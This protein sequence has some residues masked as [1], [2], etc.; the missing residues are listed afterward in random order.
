V[1]SIWVALAAASIWSPDLISGT[2]DTH[3]PIAAFTDWFYA[4][5]A[6]GLVLMAFSRRTPD[7]GRSSWAA[8]TVAISVIWLVVAITSVWSPHLISGAEDTHVPIAALVSPIAGVLAT[9]FRVGVR[10]RELGRSGGPVIRNPRDGGVPD[11]GNRTRGARDQ[12][13]VPT[14]A[15]R[16]STWDRGSA[17]WAQSSGSSHGGFPSIVKKLNRHVSQ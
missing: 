10:G 17:A 3:V 5:I 9:A 14:H 16:F 4:V 1:S 7:V 12:G 11:D 2:D 13:R 6:T 15:R 8:F